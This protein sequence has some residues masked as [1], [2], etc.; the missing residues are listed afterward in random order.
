[1]CDSGFLTDPLILG[2]TQ[3]FLWPFSKM[4]IKNLHFDENDNKI[5][6]E[7]GKLFTVY[8]SDYQYCLQN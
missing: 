5:R 4:K 6:H 7:L 1:M 3:K 2:P 8:H